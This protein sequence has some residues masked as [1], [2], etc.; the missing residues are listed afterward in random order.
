MLIR[1]GEIKFE[2]CGGLIHAWHRRHC[3]E[4]ASMDW[5][6]LESSVATDVELVK[7]GN[8]RLR[9]SWLALGHLM[10][11]PDFDRVVR[12]RHVGQRQSMHLQC[13]AQP[14]MG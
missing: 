2:W 4:E 14:F 6:A 8:Q 12:H 10:Y 13:H 1:M 7:K 11:I 9:C 5:V 3:L